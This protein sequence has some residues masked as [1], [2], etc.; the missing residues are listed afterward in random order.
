MSRAV[1]GT[2][3]GS[4]LAFN[5]RRAA[6]RGALGCDD[7]AHPHDTLP[8][9]VANILAVPVIDH[10]GNTNEVVPALVEIVDLGKAQFRAIVVWRFSYDV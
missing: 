10:V 1:P 8:V 3:A 2:V 5:R 6:E 4:G 9:I 7:L